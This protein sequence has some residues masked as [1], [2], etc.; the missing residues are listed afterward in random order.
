M[1]SLPIE[2]EGSCGVTP[3]TNYT[4]YTRSVPLSDYSNA[5]VRVD[6]LA[7]FS[8]VVLSLGGKPTTLLERAGIAPETLLKTSA[9]VPYRG[10]IYLLELAAAHLDCP[11]FGLQLAAR[12]GGMAVLGPLEVAMRNSR[13]VGE[14]YEYC[15]AHLQTYSPAVQIRIDPDRESGRHFIRHE[16]LLNRVPHQQQSVEHAVALMHHAI[17]TLSG[18]KVHSREVWF[19]H[20]PL[21]PITAYSQYFGTRVCFGKPLH[22]IFLNPNDLTVP[23]CDRSDQLYD[24]AISYIDSQYPSVSNVVSSQVRAATTHHLALGKC[25]HVGVASALGMH[26]R[27]MQRRLRDEG[28]SFE[29]IKDEVRRDLALRYLGNRTIS[30]TKVAAMLGYSEPSVLTRSCYRWFSDTPRKVRLQ[31]QKADMQEMATQ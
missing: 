14:A 2:L 15:S 30:L 25:T 8:E 12:Q 13:T 26:P 31:M 9:V 19:M 24:L 20:E 29:D 4:A 10:L 18:G 21:S 28:Q 3:F 27:T 22:G 11:S 5:M 23:L 1:A 17:Q 6:A 7:H 16:L